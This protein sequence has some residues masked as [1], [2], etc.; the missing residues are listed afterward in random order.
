MPAKNLA[1]MVLSN[2]MRSPRHFV[3]SAFGIVIGIGAFVLFLALTQRAG[4]VLEKIFPLEEVQVVAPRV[5]LLGKDASKRLDD[6]TVATI[7]ARKEVAA[8]IPRLNLAFPAAGRGD[9]EGSD[10]KFEVGGFADGVDP[11]FVRDDERIR[12]LFKDWDAETGDPNRVAC[13][14]PPKNPREDVIQSPGKPP[15]KDKPRDSAWGTAPAPSTPPPST[16]PPDPAPAPEDGGAAGAPEPRPRNRRPRRS[17]P[18]TSTRA[19]S[20][21]A[22]TATTPSGSASTACPSCCR[23]RWSSSTTTSSPSRTACRWRI[24]TW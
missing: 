5:S 12:E 7:K 16:P 21:I 23:R 22:T 13:V 6:T 2:T 10:L 8:A 18:S 19:R 17:R 20:P 4:S 11:G 9:F 14:P 24:R 3:L 1:R 15:A